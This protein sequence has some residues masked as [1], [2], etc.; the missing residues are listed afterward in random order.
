MCLFEKTIWGNIT[1]T[2]VVQKCKTADVLYSPEL[3][4]ATCW[5][6]GI[7][8]QA[9]EDLSHWYS[10]SCCENALDLKHT[11]DFRSHRCTAPQAPPKPPCPTFF[12]R[13]LSNSPH[14]IPDELHPI[15]KTHVEAYNRLECFFKL[16]NT[17]THSYTH[18][19]YLFGHA[20]S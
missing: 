5:H 13:S 1:V 14:L 12:S 20:M 7:R 10:Y 3:Y 15:K 9:W 6:Y 2:S 18:V 8:G 17:P 4:V 11:W 19:V 16:T